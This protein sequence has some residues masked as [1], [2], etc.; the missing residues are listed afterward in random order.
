MQLQVTTLDEGVTALELSGRLDL[1]G[2]RQIELSYTV[3]AANQPARV[4]VD[5]SAVDF[6]ASIGIRLLLSGAKAQ[7]Q[8]GG[9]TV[10]CGAQPAVRDVLETTGIA[11]LIPLCDSRAAAVEALLAP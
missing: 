9:R 10:I 4:L 3:H 6:V 8:R 11:A 5:L 7:M 1:A 2:S